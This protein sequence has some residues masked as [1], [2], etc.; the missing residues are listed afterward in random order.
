MKYYII[1]YFSS[2]FNTFLLKFL[3]EHYIIRNIVSSELTIQICLLLHLFIS[4][5]HKN[6]NNLIFKILLKSFHN[7]HQL[8]IIAKCNSK[9][10]RKEIPTFHPPRIDTKPIKSSESEHFPYWSYLGKTRYRHY[11]SPQ[12]GRS[13]APFDCDL[14]KNIEE[15]KDVAGHT[16]P[17]SMAL[18]ISGARSP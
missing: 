10:F 9:L 12:K 11:I 5:K 6:L 7:Q 14:F 1:T 16:R 17:W 13:R 8:V 18:D 15:G 3:P 4:A 2:I